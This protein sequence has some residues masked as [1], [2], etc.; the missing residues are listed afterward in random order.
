MNA[1]PK[2]LWPKIFVCGYGTQRCNAKAD[3]YSRYMPENALKPLFDSEISLQNPNLVILQQNEKT[4]EKLK[5]DIINI[6]MFDNKDYDIDL[7]S[8]ILEV[9]TNWG[10][11][12]YEVLG[13]GYSSTIQW[14]LDFL[15]WSIY[16]SKGQD[17]NKNYF[18]K[19]GILLLDE[20]D[21][22]LHPKWQR[23]IVQRLCNQFPKIQIIA[24]THN[25]LC[26]AGITDIDKSQLISLQEY[27]NN[28]VE[29]EIIDKDIL[30]GK[31]AD[32]VLSHAFG[33]ITSRTPGNQDDISK[34]TE[35]FGKKNRS[36]SEEEE[37]QT[38]KEQLSKSIING[39][40]EYEQT[41]EKAIQDVIKNYELKIPKEL[42]DIE[43]KQK[44]KEL[45]ND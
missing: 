22:H 35:L 34:Y 37:F 21:Q 14:I 32:Q 45:F 4:R 18:D 9:K 28:N 38:L 5:K 8:N 15:N 29:P 2:L 41:V 27:D 13:D 44:L 12:S 36:S 11:L 10:K 42:L 16:A 30:K 24:A 1:D 40:N 20:L 7:S 6:L 39:E 33:L 43:T 26:A 31:R 25:P 23:Y 19:G 17:D 3:T